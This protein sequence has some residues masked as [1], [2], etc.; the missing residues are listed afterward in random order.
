MRLISRWTV[1]IMV[2]AIVI[3]SWILWH[4]AVRPQILISKTRYAHIHH[5]YWAVAQFNGARHRLPKSLAEVVE[6][7][8]LPEHVTIYYSPLQ[9]DTL[10][11]G[12]LPYSACEFD[13]SFSPDQVL[14][15]VPE[16]GYGKYKR[17]VKSPS[18]MTDVVT[19][20]VTAF[21]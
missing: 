13:M 18:Y 4:F 21:R 11:E 20:D 2:S 6:A 15:S 8:Y 12:I 9:H 17:F 19:N 5:I 1:I 10:F 7:G 14:I 16:N 3:C